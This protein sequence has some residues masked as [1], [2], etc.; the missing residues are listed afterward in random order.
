MELYFNP[1]S[2]N[3]IRDHT[4]GILSDLL[5]EVID[6]V[7]GKTGEDMLSVAESLNV[8]RH[9]TLLHSGLRDGVKSVSSAINEHHIPSRKRKRTTSPSE[10]SSSDS[11]TKGGL[12]NGRVRNE[13]TNGHMHLSSDDTSTK[14]SENKQL[15]VTCSSEILKQ[16]K[17]DSKIEPPN[18][19]ETKPRSSVRT[20]ARRALL[21]AKKEA[22]KSPE[23][24]T[25]VP[26]PQ[27]SAQTKQPDGKPKKKR[28]PGKDLHKKCS[29]RFIS[30]EET[31]LIDVPLVLDPDEGDLVSLIQ[32]ECPKNW[33]VG[34]QRTRA[35]RKKYFC[36][37]CT[38]GE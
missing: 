33:V 38:L 13:L 25:P 22:N 14:P 4:T 15:H 9:N 8:N 10:E 19:P 1:G 21:E 35:F 20:S 23:P 7:R 5:S 16:S 31:M 2:R 3:P 27:N 36:R 28:K 26:T 12:E 29:K 34:H 32:S 11:E 17:I 6:R 24:Q 30:L 37:K 18:P